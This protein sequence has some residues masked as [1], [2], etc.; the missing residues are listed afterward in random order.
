MGTGDEAQAVD[1]VEFSGNLVA[2]EPAGATRGYSPGVDIF[3]VTPH[4]VAEGSLVGD[5]L[6]TCNNSDLIDCADLGAQ[7]AVDTEDFSVD[8][9]GEDQE[10]KDLAA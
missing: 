5:L 3:G 4:Q 2:E 6:R 8:D 10:I 1:M 9:G 7:A